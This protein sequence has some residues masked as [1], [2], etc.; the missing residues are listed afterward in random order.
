M[1]PA[2]IIAS[3]QDLAKL[4][5][6]ARSCDA[7]ALDTEFVWERTYYPQLGLIQIGLSGEKCY[8]IDPVAIKDLSPLGTLLADKKVI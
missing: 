1:N 8:V 6:E 7:V 5:E 3:D 4:M 2:L